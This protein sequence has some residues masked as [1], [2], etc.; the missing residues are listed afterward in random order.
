MEHHESYKPC[1]E[2]TRVSPGHV[3]SSTHG[4]WCEVAGSLAGLGE[5]VVAGQGALGTS[6][7][8]PWRGVAASP[9][10]HSRGSSLHW[11]EPR[12]LFTS[13]ALGF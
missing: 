4:A 12:T 6:T 13:Q 8:Q 5:C 11:L 7:A 3:C 1:E 9:R 10:G 2:G